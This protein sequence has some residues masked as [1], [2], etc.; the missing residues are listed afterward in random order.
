MAVARG[1][2]G[3]FSII[4]S[5]GYRLFPGSKAALDASPNVVLAGMLWSISR[6]ASFRELL[7]TGAIECGALI[8]RVAT[9]AQ[10]INPIP[11]A[12]IQALTKARPVD[13]RTRQQTLKGDRGG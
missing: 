10:D 6:V 1:L 8:D 11:T 9:A 5:L 4:K 12:S 2:H 7:A 13:H 3:G